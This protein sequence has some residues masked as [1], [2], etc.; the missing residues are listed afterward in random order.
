[1][2]EGASFNQFGKESG[3]AEDDLDRVVGGEGLYCTGAAEESES[4]GDQFGQARIEKSGG[5]FME[6]IC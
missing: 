2:A 5:P 6:K 1:L 3:P 4:L